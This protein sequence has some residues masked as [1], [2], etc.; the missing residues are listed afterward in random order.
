[1]GT[2]TLQALSS[3]PADLMI[4]IGCFVLFAA[5]ALRLG[6]NMVCSFG[7]A[8]LL[9][10]SVVALM[11][12]AFLVGGASF[13]TSAPAVVFFA[14]LLVLFFVM[15]QILSI[16]FEYN[17]PLPA[18]ACAAGTSIIILVVWQ[19]TAALQPFWDFGSSVDA[20]FVPKYYFWLILGALGAL[21]FSRI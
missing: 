5:I 12:S 7:L 21:V 11:P 4:I 10:P 17:A 18:L 6:T 13:L 8:W 19:Q 15:Y 9:T 20:L 14:V 1:M 3:V 2:S 16:G